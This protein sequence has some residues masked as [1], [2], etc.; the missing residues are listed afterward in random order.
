MANLPR[1]RWLCSTV[2][3]SNL[4]AGTY[5]LQVKAFGMTAGFDYGLDVTVN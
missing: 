5:Y 4:P 3:V 2:S 1:R